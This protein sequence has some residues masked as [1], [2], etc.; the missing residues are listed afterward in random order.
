MPTNL[1]PFATQTHIAHS[2][3]PKFSLAKQYLS[4]KPTLP[5][6]F[7]IANLPPV[8]LIPFTLFYFLPL[9]LTIF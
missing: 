5:I 4:T 2:F 3:L 8:L 1:F 6:T 9:A 7:L